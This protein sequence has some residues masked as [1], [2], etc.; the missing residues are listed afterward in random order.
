VNHGFESDIVF[1]N[2][3]ARRFF[4]THALTPGDQ[5]LHA[6]MAGYWARFVAIGEPGG[7]GDELWRRYGEPQ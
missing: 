4:P 7:S 2:N 3:Y 5:S 6:R 1:G